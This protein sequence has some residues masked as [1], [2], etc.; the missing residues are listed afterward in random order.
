MS[1]SVYLWWGMGLLLIVAE[2]LAPG[3]FL[4]WIGIAALL[5]GVL[6][7]FVPDLGWLSQSVLFGVLAVASIQV[8]RQFVRPRERKSDQPLLNRRV[9]QMVGRSFVLDSAIVG[10][11]GKIRIGDA[12]WTV[13][14]E[15]APAGT[16]VVVTGADGITLE[17][18]AEA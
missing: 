14:G 18:R 8:Y 4:L 1:N 12:L 2:L 6:M 13:R 11:T 5:M 17:V 7:L 16:R 9:D 15:D 3:V 10:G